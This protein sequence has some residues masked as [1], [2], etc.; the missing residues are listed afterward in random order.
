M[1]MTQKTKPEQHKT[2]KPKK[3]GTNHSKQVK[4]QVIALCKK[5]D[6][7]PAHAFHVTELGLKLFDELRTLGL[8]QLDEQY[9]LLFKYGCMLHDIG[10]ADGQERHHKRAFTMIIKSDLQLSTEHKQMVALI[11]R[12]HRKA[13]PAGQ[14]ELLKLRTPERES[15]A[16]LAAIIR[17]VDVLD[18]FHDQKVKI[19]AVS[20][21]PAGV[22]I[23][24]SRDFLTMIPQSTLARKVAFFNKAFGIPALIVDKPDTTDKDNTITKPK[25]T[26]DSPK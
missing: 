9:R 1:L 22:S 7:D 3:P 4:K 6:P 8:H 24:I 25:P 10:W 13:E 17:T 21:S 14:A 5:L 16:K 23:V 18:R 11:A 15:V 12:F 26:T 20:L 2:G 19:K